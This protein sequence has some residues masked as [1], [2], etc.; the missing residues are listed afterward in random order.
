ML[1]WNSRARADA[2]TVENDAI[3]RRLCPN[4]HGFSGGDR[5]F[6][7]IYARF[8][9]DGRYNE[10]SFDNP[11]YYDR[12]SFIGRSL[13]SSYAP[14]ETDGNYTEFVAALSGLFDK[15][16]VGGVLEMRNIARLTLGEV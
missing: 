16:A 9:K 3:C 14:R 6:T 12:E 8:F 7:G 11:L 15:Y 13:S 2:Q 10:I 5:D 1:V 4:Y